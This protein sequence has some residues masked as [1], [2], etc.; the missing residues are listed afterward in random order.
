[1]PDVVLSLIQ[2]DVQTGDVHK[3]LATAERLLERAA[4][5]RSQLV[6][7]PEMWNTGFAYEELLPLA[8][9]TFGSTVE[10][11]AG[12]A[13]R[14]QMMIVGSIPEATENGAANTL[15]WVDA[16]GRLIGRYRKVHLFAPMGEDA[17]FIAGD[18]PGIFET[19]FGVFGGMIC[20]DLR[21]PD[22]ASATVAAGAWCLIVPAQFPNPRRSHWETLLAARA[23][24]NQVYVVGVNRVGSSGGIEFFGHSRLIDPWGNIVD[25][26]G[27][28]EE[29]VVTRLNPDTVQ[30]VRSTLPS[31]QRRRVEL[32]ARWLQT[33]AEGK[34]NAKAYGG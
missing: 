32:Y 10:F 7:L 6:V 12:W 29:L 21:F 5:A 33:E 15:I 14:G 24:E 17:H 27:D 28:R 19:P 9:A 22:L 34:L 23:I 4:N 18:S 3:N 25:G 31:W 1:M 13:R 11:L 26:A 20:Y 8:K 30:Q 16:S 2:M